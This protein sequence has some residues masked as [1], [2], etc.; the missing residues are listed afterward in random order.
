MMDG[1][2]IQSIHQPAI[3]R[4]EFIICGYTRQKDMAYINQE[5]A[6]LPAPANNRTDL[7]IILGVAA[8]VS[9]VGLL[10]AFSIVPGFGLYCYVTLHHIDLCINNIRTIPSL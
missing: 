4:I 6:G 1:I 9:F 3:S 5:R 10:I 8:V 7:Y 2:Y